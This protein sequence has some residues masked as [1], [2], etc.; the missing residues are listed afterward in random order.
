MTD[1]KTSPPLDNPL[2]LGEEDARHDMEL[3]FYAYR[4]FTAEADVV[5]ARHGLGRAHHRALYFIGRNAGIT[6]SE[7]LAILR[8]TK[9]SLARVLNDLVQHG[10]VVQRTGMSDRRRRHLDLTEKGAELERHLMERQRARIV[11][12]YRKAGAG[13]IE[14][15]RKVLTGMINEHDRERLAPSVPPARPGTR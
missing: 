9:Q 6:V 10:F 5:L 4:D 12:A 3:L 2:F 15:Y 13:A 7:L 14:D 8:I 1:V 11:S